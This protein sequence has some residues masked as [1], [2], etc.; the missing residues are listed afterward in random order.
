MKDLVL[1]LQQDFTYPSYSCLVEFRE[2][3]KRDD[4]LADRFGDRI[5]SS[6]AQV[7]E[8]RLQVHGGRFRAQSL[9]EKE[10]WCKTIACQPLL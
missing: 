2:H 7:G 5:V 3:R 8:C 6:L 1:H 4:V 9:C 10:R